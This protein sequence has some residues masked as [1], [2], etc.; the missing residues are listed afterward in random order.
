MGTSGL[1]V[2]LPG[3]G[4]HS[5]LR[6]CHGE[7]SSM[8][9]VPGPNVSQSSIICSVFQMMFLSTCDCCAIL[10]PHWWTECGWM[11]LNTR[12]PLWLIP[13]GCVLDILGD[14][15]HGSFLP[16]SCNLIQQTL[17]LS[18]AWAYIGNAEPLP[19]GGTAFRFLA[20]DPHSLIVNPL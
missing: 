12:F 1:G 6:S 16:F 5:L 9:V 2:Q 17:M 19:E 15:L 4:R 14:T 11:I 18:L 10:C 20:I 13:V 8:I 7:L 3:R